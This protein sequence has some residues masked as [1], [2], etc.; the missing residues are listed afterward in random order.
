MCRKTLPYFVALASLAAGGCTDRPTATAPDA[1]ATPS[2][3]SGAPAG[4]DEELARALALGLR[5]PV[6]RAYL[7]AKLQASPYR[8]QKVHFQRFLYAGGQHALVA[9]AAETRVPVGVVA[10]TARAAIPLEVY[11]PVPAHRAAWMGDGRVLVATAL[12]DGDAPVAYDTAGNRYLLNPETPPAIPVLALVPVETNFATAPSVMQ[13]YE[14]CGGGGGGRGS[15]WSP[16][17]TGLYMTQAHFTQTFESWLKGSPEFEVHILGQK[18]Q[19]DSLMDYQC[20]GELQP[21]PYS[22]DQNDLDWSGS[23]MLFSQTQLDSYKS[24]HPGQSV[25]VYVVE[26]DDTACQIKTSSGRLAKALAAVD[27]LAQ[28]RAAGNDTTTDAGKKFT[29]ARSVV[30]FFDAVVSLINTND[31]LV[32]NAVADSVAGEYHTGADW[33][34]KGESNVTNGWIKLEMR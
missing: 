3:V 34:V 9:I 15:D 31:D 16:P 33:I 12:R 23:L 11:L 2:P 13:C 27:T 28:G 6:L 22:F 20:A 19:S 32:G 21:V 8:E 5:S 7:R 30:S 1:F 17:T 18:G 25:R 24:A 14:W 26:D 4:P 10:G 29:W